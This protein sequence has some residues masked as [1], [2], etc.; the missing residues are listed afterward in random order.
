MSTPVPGPPTATTSVDPDAL[1]ETVDAA[2]GALDD[3]GSDAA[4]LNEQVHT[5]EELHRRLAAA[6]TTLDSA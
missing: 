2:L 6:L 5:L 4:G 3:T 1:V